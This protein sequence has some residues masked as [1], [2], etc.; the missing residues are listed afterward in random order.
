MARLFA[1]AAATALCAACG[2]ATSSTTTSLANSVPLDLVEISV[3]VGIDSG[4][5]R[6]E[7]VPL[8]AVVRVTLTNPDA[9]DEYHLH[10][11]DLGSGEVEAGRTAVFEFEA[12]LPGSFEI[13]SHSL[14]LVLIVLNIS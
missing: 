3:S 13:E 9:A 8:G 14:E 1:L 5:D 4:A 2:S 7:E 10:G 11:Y 6:V 12:S